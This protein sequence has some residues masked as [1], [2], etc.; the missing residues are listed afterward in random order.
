MRARTHVEGRS[1]AH[2]TRHPRGSNPIRR[3]A[4]GY[5]RKVTDARGPFLPPLRPPVLPLILYQPSLSVLFPTL[6]LS[7]TPREIER[8]RARARLSVD[9]AAAAAV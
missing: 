7:F 8:A 5:P 3:H 9:K 6:N 2:L 1:G 4:S